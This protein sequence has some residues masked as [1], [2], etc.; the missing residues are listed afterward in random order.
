MTICTGNVIYGVVQRG[1]TGKAVQSDTAARKAGKP[2]TWKLAKQRRS[3]HHVCVKH[4][5]IFYA[6]L[7]NIKITDTAQLRQQAFGRS[8]PSDGRVRTN[9]ALVDASDIGQ[10]LH[11]APS[12]SSKANRTERPVWHFFARP[13]SRKTSQRL[14]IGCG[15][16]SYNRRT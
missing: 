8:V 5:R 6:A 14:K 2:A 4:S 15:L 10:S 9:H 1:G 11:K 7:E 3:L 13:P 12:A 16:I